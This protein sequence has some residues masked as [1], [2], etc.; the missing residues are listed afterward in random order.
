MNDFDSVAEDVSPTGVLSP[1]ID[2]GVV[3]PASKVFGFA[4][5]KF[6]RIRC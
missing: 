1:V 5:K 2:V 6:Y 4:E 3:T